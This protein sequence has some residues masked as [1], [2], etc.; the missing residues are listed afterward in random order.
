MIMKG[1]SRYILK[2]L[3][4]AMAFVTFCLTCAIWLTQSLRYIELIVNHGISLG[5]FLYLTM[6]LL[7]SFLSIVLPI[8]LFSS[9][10]F[11]Y[12]KLWM[13]RELVV[14]RAV[15]VSQLSLS[16]PALVMAVVVMIAGF[17]LNLYFMPAAYRSFKDMEFAIKNDFSAILL[18]EGKFNTLSDGL[19]VYVRERASNGELLGILVHDTRQPNKPVTY[20]AERGAI[21]QT[22]EG[23]RVVL[24]NGNRQQ[25]ERKDGRLSL[26][27]FD[28]YSVD[29]SW[30]SQGMESRWRRPQERFLGELLHPDMSDPND[31]ANYGQLITEAHQRLISP[32]YA[33]AFSLIGLAA[34]LSGEFN[35]QGQTI[36]ILTAVVCVVFLQSSAIGIQNLVGKNLPLLPLLY[37]NCFGPLLIALI[38]L[39][40]PPRRRPA[41][42][43]RI[44]AGAA[45]AGGV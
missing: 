20:I 10:L 18:Q 5:T 25:V 43:T 29:L 8:A 12:N 17:A 38:Y 30:I 21:V 16:V 39:L 45:G 44:G 28:K 22:S 3:G 1:H 34:L 35:R 2:Q 9:I 33:I 36:R 4:V 32:F 15:G 23:P 24:V 14:L 40:R 42:W 19:T 41:F 27:Y 26:L 11:T 37:L 6:L 31:R 13:D 7:P